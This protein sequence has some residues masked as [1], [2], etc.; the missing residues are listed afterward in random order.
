M[1]LMWETVSMDGTVVIG[2]GE[3]DRAPMLYSGEQ[4][5][6]GEPPE[7]DIAV[8]PVDGTT[9]TAK[10]MGGALSG[11]ALAARGAMFDPGPCFYMEKI[12]V[13]EEAVEAI[14]IE[15]PVAENLARVAKAKRTDIED[16]TVIMLDRPR[17]EG[18]AKE[19]R[20]AGARIRFIT[21]GDVAAAIAAAREGSGID[22]LMGIGGTPEG[23]LSACA[24]KCLGGAIQGRLSPRG[25][26]E[27]DATLA[28]GYDLDQILTV[29]D[30]VS[31]D[32][33][34]FAATGVTDG[35]LLRGVRYRQQS[36]VTQSISMRSRSGT[37]RLIE[38][39]HRLEK[40]SEY[41]R[42]AY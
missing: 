37:V 31:G 34:Y 32:D 25:E 22:V 38:A 28:A 36:A 6:N 12:A 30:L 13:G 8:D 29:D 11:I 21:D 1:R 26:E 33:V 23:V 35:N 18:L 4:I 19:V 20:E 7:V 40:L 17:H 14:D 9:L 27:R 24:I 5:G 16:L 41:S 3:K 2:E 10:G 39:V 15:A 42:I